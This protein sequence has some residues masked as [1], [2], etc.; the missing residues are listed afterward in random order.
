MFV[1]KGP[2]F[3]FFFKEGACKRTNTFFIPSK[4]W[5][6]LKQTQKKRKLKKEKEN[7][8]NVLFF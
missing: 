3:F 7:D 5:E 4:C 8:M 6:L 1:Q 2:R